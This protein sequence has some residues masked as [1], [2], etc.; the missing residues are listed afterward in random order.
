MRIT[1]GEW[2]GRPLIAPAGTATR[3]TSDKVR[4]ALFNLLGPQIANAA[5]LD[6][7][8]GTG[9]IGLEA[10]SRGA[11]RAVAVESSPPALSTLRKNSDSLGAALEIISLPAERALKSF[12]VKGE[13]FDIVFLDPPY[14]HDAGPLL[15]LLTPLLNPGA[16]VILEDA[17]RDP[18]PGSAWGD[19]LERRY[20]DT[21]LLL[22]RGVGATSS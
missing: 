2:R 22:W 10:L 19:P 14:R 15:P 11:A 13:S 16:T 4:Q 12:A 5:L 8:A 20:G 9:A 3:P 18:V 17:V 21:R 1:G 6:L 7:F